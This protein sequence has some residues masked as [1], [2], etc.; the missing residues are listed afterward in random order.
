MYTKLLL[1]YPPPSLPNTNTHAYDIDEY[2]IRERRTHMG[3][4]VDK[5]GGR[6]I[7]FEKSADKVNPTLETRVKNRDL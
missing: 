2:V 4:P 5:R 6:L 1:P 3:Y 7:G